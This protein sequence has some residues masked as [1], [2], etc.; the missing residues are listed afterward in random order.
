MQRDRRLVLVGR[1]DPLI[2]SAL[3]LEGYEVLTIVSTLGLPSVARDALA[4]I[5][6]QLPKIVAQKATASLLNIGTPV[7]PVFPE[8]PNFENLRGQLRLLR[9]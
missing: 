5:F 4:V 1:A 3:R 9:P 8:E 7:I 6:Y 2:L